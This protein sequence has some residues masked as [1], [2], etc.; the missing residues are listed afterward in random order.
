[1]RLTNQ[2]WAG[3]S[4][5]GESRIFT[6]YHWLDETGRTVEFDGER[7]PLP[8]VIAAGAT[9]EVSLNILSPA[10]PGRY[11]LAIDLVQEGLT[12]FSQAG[13]PCLEIPFD[14]R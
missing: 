13:W 9:R 5:D 8:G 3:W 7:T 6:S 4:S 10:T 12:W 2:G 1:M 11:R 14:V